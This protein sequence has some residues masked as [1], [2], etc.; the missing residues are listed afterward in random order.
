MARRRQLRGEKEK[1]TKSGAGSCRST[2]TGC[3]PASLALCKGCLT[4][5]VF[6]FVHQVGPSLVKSPVVSKL[7][8]DPNRPLLA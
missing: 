3:A 1:E 7:R 2:T 6:Y 8:K 4:T 5:E